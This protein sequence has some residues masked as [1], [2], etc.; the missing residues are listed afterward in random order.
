MLQQT[1]VAA[2]RPYFQRFTERWPTVQ[3]LAVADDGDLMG[4]WAGLG[5]YARARNLLACARTVATDHDGRFPSTAA[6]LRDLPGVGD[7]TSAAIAAI[8]FGEPVAVVDGN[9]ERVVTRLAAVETAMPAARAAVRGIV[10]AMVP[11]DRP[12]DFAQAMMDLG[13]TVCTP[14]RPAC[15]LC[16]LSETCDA[17]LAGTQE[18][19]PVKLAK[20]PKPQ[21]KGA[22]F[23]AIRMSDDA[24]WLRRRPPSGLLGGMAEPPSTGWSSRADGA[25]GSGAAPFEAEW[26]QAGTVEHGFT[27]FDL[28]LEVWTSRI[29]HTPAGEGWWAAAELDGKTQLPTLMRKAIERARGTLPVR[30]R[31]T[32]A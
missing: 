17:R 2:V 11:A 31:R 22:V 15:I 26:T 5:Y 27:H 23:V 25:C 28:A 8:A 32:P 7:Y 24:V 12:G 4:A 9:V 21:R 10:D 29:D 30:P 16:P 13:A 19:Y 1:T 20:R 18:R 14:K 6:S 3:A